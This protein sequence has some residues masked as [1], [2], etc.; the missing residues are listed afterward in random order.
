MG[1]QL[2]PCPST[3]LC[4]MLLEWGLCVPMDPLPV[5]SRW[6]QVTFPSKHFV[7]QWLLNRET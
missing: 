1:A 4:R 5:I 7:G 3:L 2:R 6:H